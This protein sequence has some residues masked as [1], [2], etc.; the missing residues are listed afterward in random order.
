MG[1]GRHCY[2]TSVEDPDTNAAIHLQKQRDVD[3]L[4]FL[5]LTHPHD[6]HYRG[7]SQFFDHFAIK[8]YWQFAGMTPEDANL[9]KHALATGI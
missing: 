2:A 1:R 4:E 7:M 3:Q 9:V 5:C 6:D 8:Y